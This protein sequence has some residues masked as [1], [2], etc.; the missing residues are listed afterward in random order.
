MENNKWALGVLAVIGLVIIAWVLKE[1]GSSPQLP[2]ISA[3]VFIGVI[4]YYLFLK[5]PV[6][7]T[8]LRQHFGEF[9]NLVLENSDNYIHIEKKDQITF[10]KRSQPG[11]Q[12]SIFS[13]HNGNCL[14]MR[15]LV[16]RDNTLLLNEDF[17]QGT[18]IDFIIDYVLPVF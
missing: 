7:A 9:I 18:N 17:N 1:L 5:P 11:K 13:Y 14:V 12:M 2:I 15:V 8:L 10:F 3:L 4:I 6:K 16:S